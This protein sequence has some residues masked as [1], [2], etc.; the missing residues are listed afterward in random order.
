[1]SNS[2]AI[3]AV[4]A[5]LCNLLRDVTTPVDEEGPELADTDVSA[6]PP[7]RITTQDE[8][9]RINVYLF[10][11]QPNA[12]CRNLPPQS[13]GA[14]STGQAPLALNLS[15]LLTAYGRQYDEILA[16]RLLGRAMAILHSHATLTA[17]DIQHISKQVQG[18]D[19][20][21]QVER[22][23]IRPQS[24]SNDEMSKLWSM[25]GAKYRASV[26][27]QLSVVLIDGQ[28]A[29]RTPL[30]VIKRAVTVQPQTS[31]GLP[32]LRS[33]TTSPLPQGVRIHYQKQKPVGDALIISGENLA[34]TNLT[35]RFHHKALP[36][37]HALE[38]HD[39]L[40]AT[41]LRVSVPG[42]L[43]DWPVGIY[44][45]AV[46]RS[47]GNGAPPASNGNHFS[48]EQSFV[49]LPTIRKCALASRN[50]LH[51]TCSPQVWPQQR[52]SLLV[53]EYEIPAATRSEKTDDLTFSVAEIPRGEHLV[54]L[55]IDGIESS[56]LV[57]NSA[58]PEFDGRFKVT[59]A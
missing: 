21:K 52:V 5:T 58:V 30:P 11:L 18:N 48:N 42:D 29:T 8:H 23:H 2:L 34:G 43:D 40:N 17:E 19:L 6:L 45:V 31:S 32:T 12:Q 3:A 50:Q 59:L 26:A 27:Y 44:A 53:S 54:R 57:A 41:E 56:L 37:T 39:N 47:S 7:E 25:F 1:M 13:G 15:Y 16:Q 55:C 22:I 35:L 49:L 28:A 36:V 38:M 10:Q 14:T 33:L 51:V 20:A 4:T 9:N 24:I 46:C